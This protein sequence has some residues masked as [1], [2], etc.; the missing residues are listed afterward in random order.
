MNTKLW[1]Q[2]KIA[3]ETDLS[4]ED[5]SCDAEFIDFNMDSL[6]TLTLAFDLESLLD[7]GEIDPTLFSEYNTINKLVSWIE[8]QK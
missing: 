7:I 4:I 2:E 8:N 1:L 6:S 5:V 3:E